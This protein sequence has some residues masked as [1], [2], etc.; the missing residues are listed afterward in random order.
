MGRKGKETTMDERKIILHLH[1]EG[2]PIQIL[3]T[4]LEE[5]VKQHLV[6]FKTKHWSIEQG[7]DDQQSSTVGERAYRHCSY[8]RSTNSSI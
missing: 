6:L 2:K 1:N 8:E 5:A 3:H 7:K 4:W